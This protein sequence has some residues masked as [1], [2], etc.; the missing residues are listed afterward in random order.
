M[1]VYV[2]EPTNPK[3]LSKDPQ[4]NTYWDVYTGFVCVAESVEEAARMRPEEC[5]EGRRYHGTDLDEDEKQWMWPCTPDQLTVTLIATDAPGPSRVI[6]A[7][8]RRG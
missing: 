7:S 3:L 5:P 1:N 2:V 6:L 8:F 4:G